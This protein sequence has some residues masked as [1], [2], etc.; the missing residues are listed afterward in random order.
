M[1]WLTFF[2]M[3]QGAFLGCV[4]VLGLI[5]GS[6]LNVVIFR[7]PKMLHRE[8]A[9]QCVDY[10]QEHAQFVPKNLISN[11][12]EAFNLITPRSRCPHCQHEISAFENIP[13]LSFVFQRGRCSACHK[14]IS[15]RYPL[16]EIT[17]ALFSLIVA[18]KF[19][20]SWQTIGAL[21]LTW[22]LIVLAAIDLEHQI[23]PD[24]ITLPLLWL[25]LL[26]NSQEL[27]TSLNSA[28]LGVV[29]GYLFLWSI[30][31]IFK[32]ITH[33]EGMGYGDFK[34]LAMLGAWVGW[35]ALPII[36]LLSSFCGALVGISLVALKRHER[37]QPIPFGPFL[38]LA[39][40]ITLIWGDKLSHLYLSFAGLA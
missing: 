29:G 14:P 32:L 7:L 6:F 12:T 26:V 17:T 37:S 30:Y 34:L 1:E 18:Y 40:W 4:A 23:L 31:W 16:F 33:K 10:L 9:N 27:F 19:G 2:K 8:W 3:S 24:D 28:L 21:F 5:I 11:T 22:S 13:V 20:V 36:I 38:A 25:G 15:W 35:Q 39:G